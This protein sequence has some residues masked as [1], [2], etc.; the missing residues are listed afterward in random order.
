VT[1]HTLAW[2]REDRLRMMQAFVKIMADDG[3]MGRMVPGQVA[4]TYGVP[5]SAV[6][7]E[8]MKHLSEGDGK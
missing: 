7:A 1:P 3:L 2:P 8:T 4:A 6:H 5:V